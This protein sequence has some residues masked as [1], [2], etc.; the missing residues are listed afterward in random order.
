MKKFQI[1]NPPIMTAVLISNALL[2]SYS[3]DTVKVGEESLPVS[4][5]YQKGLKEILC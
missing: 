5:K 2:I 1:F 4:R 3:Q